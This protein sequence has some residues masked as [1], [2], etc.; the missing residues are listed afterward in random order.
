MRSSYI[1]FVCTC[2]YVNTFLKIPNSA[3]KVGMNLF[4]LSRQ[5]LSIRTGGNLS[6]K[7][8]ALFGMEFVFTLSS[9]NT[10]SNT[11]FN[12]QVGIM[13]KLSDFCRCFALSLLHNTNRWNTKMP[14]LH[15]SL[16]WDAAPKSHTAILFSV[17]S[18]PSLIEAHTLHFENRL[19][20]VISHSSCILLAT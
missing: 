14:I 20:C 3:A 4:L 13:V 12:G 5:V 15:T 2:L 1:V 17:L 11:H 16:S 9:W 18:R 19:S 8:S 6:C 10:R 7:E